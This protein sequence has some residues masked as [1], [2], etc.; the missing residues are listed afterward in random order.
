MGKR[1]AGVNSFK[2]TVC[3]AVNY[4]RLFEQ[5]VSVLTLGLGQ[6]QNTRLGI[7]TSAKS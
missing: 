2:I 3:A 7:K 5:K 1:V 4:R 6:D